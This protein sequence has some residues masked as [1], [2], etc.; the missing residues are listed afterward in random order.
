MTIEEQNFIFDHITNT[1]LPV[2]DANTKKLLLNELRTIE[3]KNSKRV[4]EMIALEPILDAK[5][6]E[7][8]DLLAEVNTKILNLTNLETRITSLEVNQDNV[9]IDTLVDEIILRLT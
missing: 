2:Q 4:L 9:D 7:V 1:I 8:T 3:I 5:I 6:L